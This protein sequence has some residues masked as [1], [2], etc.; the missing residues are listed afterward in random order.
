MLQKLDP[1]W[2]YF[3]RYSPS[4]DAY[5]KSLHYFNLYRLIVSG[6]FV[7]IFVFFGAMPVYGEQSAGMFLIVSSLYV[8]F[9]TLMTLTIST[10]WPAFNLQL[11]AHTLGDVVFIVLLM[12][13]SGGIKSGLGLLLVVALAAS[14]LI[15]KGRQAM[16][17]AAMA[18]I[19]VLLEQSYQLFV[20]GVED[21]YFQAALLSMGFFATAGMGY[22]LSRQVV[23]SERLAEQKSID[24]E[25]LSQ[26]NALVIQSMQDGVMVVDDKG[27]VRSHNAQCERLLG[28]PSR[29][30]RDL[31]LYDYAPAIAERLARWRSDHTLHFPPLRVSATGKQ[32]STRFSPIESGA[33]AGAVVFLE[34][35]SQQ[36]AQS[37]QVKLA[38]LGRLT[39]N[40]AHEIRNPLSA[41][42]HATQLLQEE[43]HDKTEARLL[44]IIRDN[45]LRLDRMVQDVLQLNRR[46]RAQR[47]TLNLDIFLGGFI[48]QFCLAEKIPAAAISLEMDTH[49]IVCFDRS[50]LHQILWNLCR[51][52]WRH[53][54]QSD[55]SIRLYVSAAHLDNVVQIDVIDDG[56]GVDKGLAGQ[57]FEPFFT[58]FSSGTGLGL[59]IAREICEANNASLDYIEVAPGGQFRICC[60]GGPC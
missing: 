9:S 22:F 25:N 1:V 52:A 41:I 42:G 44:Q 34:D 60:K 7:T 50:H 39:A 12:H 18:S 36:Q 10:R 48:E 58:T 24:L 15:C 49:P 14:S 47:E 33:E 8:V 56:P 59:Y 40:I 26:V 51:N 43:E 29:F 37:Q 20:L 3:R 16:F 4:P 57:L 28:T 2:A 11:S 21:D 5:W 46:D 45:T 31:R 38:A 17:Y 6:L 55:A 30:R 27:R 19:A 13:A 54:Q 23:E 35:V 53:S 32:I